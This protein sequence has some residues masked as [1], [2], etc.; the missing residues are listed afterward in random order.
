MFFE[1]SFEKCGTNSYKVIKEGGPTGWLSA[2]DL[3]QELK[4]SLDGLFEIGIDTIPYKYTDIRE[5]TKHKIAHLFCF[6]SRDGI[7]QY[8]GIRE[9]NTTHLR[10]VV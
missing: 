2:L 5:L 9:Y 1:V 7:I 6:K 3:K 10:Q 8:V 4:A